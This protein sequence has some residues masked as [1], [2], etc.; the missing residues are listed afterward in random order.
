[1]ENA[2]L[3]RRCLEVLGQYQIKVKRTIFSAWLKQ[4]HKFKL[5][6]SYVNQ[7]FEMKQREKC[8]GLLNDWRMQV[9]YK[10]KEKSNEKLA[11][12]F[13]LKHLMSRIVHEWRAYTSAQAVKHQFDRSR[14]EEF[15][16]IQRN[17]LTRQIFEVWMQKTA[18][19]I[20]IERK[21]QLAVTIEHRNLKVKAF[22]AWRLYVRKCR[23]QHLLERQAQWFLEM[24][25]KRQVYNVWFSK[26][27]ETQRLEDKNTRALLFWSINIQKTCFSA[28]FQR[29]RS[30]KAK[31]QRYKHAM[32]MRHCDIMKNCAR[33]F[34]IY[35]MDSK[36]RRLKANAYLK[37]KIWTN[38]SEL[39]LKYFYIW[40]GKC[41]TK[42]I[43]RFISKL[44][45]Q[46]TQEP[47]ATNRKPVSVQPS[48][49]KREALMDINYSKEFIETKT[50]ARPAP[51]K[52]SYITESI[53]FGHRPANVEPK[54]NDKRQKE[55]APVIPSIQ[56]QPEPPRM[57]SMASTSSVLL[58]PTAFMTTLDSS[59][60]PSP[61]PRQS[62]QPFTSKH[63][64]L[65]LT[66]ASLSA[67]SEASS[68]A[69]IAPVEF[70]TELNYVRIDSTRQG[71]LMP[72]SPKTQSNLKQISPS[73]F[74]TV[75][76]QP[77]STAPNT[78]RKN[79]ESSRDL[80]ELK[81]RLETLNINSDKLK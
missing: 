6:N 44:D 60:R 18:S 39:E 15:G 29:H 58:P 63:E 75:S 80:V 57:S 30:K 35:S 20:E 7:Q 74:S 81:K 69:T 46:D 47:L 41:K 8:A 36:Q 19:L 24:Q 17:L 64:E 45:Q 78:A 13:Y 72:L 11:M 27:Q 40:L 23:H 79:R 55:T 56:V 2:A 4:T 34:I 26:H 66:F 70:Q 73:G 67:R 62:T 52:P 5:I 61:S 3:E 49:E 28:W 48:L 1:M 53:D 33:H 38:E 42:K 68:V 12:T 76:S 21:I 16:K 37:E 71:L 31:E 65:R 10:K 77:A 43:K 32:Q 25:I 14:I 51:R 9:V 54:L 22:I 50:R 59:S